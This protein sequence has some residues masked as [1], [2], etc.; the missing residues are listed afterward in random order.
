M[1]L[2][3]RNKNPDEKSAPANEQYQ[4]S[5]ME[6]GL[7]NISFMHQSTGLNACHVSS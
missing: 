7:G 6:R 5:E 2:I 1:Y 3:G 4:K